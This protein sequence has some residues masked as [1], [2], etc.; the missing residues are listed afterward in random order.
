MKPILTHVIYDLDGLLLDT[1]SLYT[2][3]NL[4]LLAPFG[5]SFNWELK[6]NMLGRP[7][8]EAVGYL[9][10][11]LNLPISLEAYLKKREAILK[12]LFPSTKP[13]PGASSI[14]RYFEEKGTPQ[15]IATSSNADM[16][17]LKTQMHQSW[18]S[19]ISLVITGEDPKIQHGKPAPDIFLLAAERMN[20]K[21]EHCLVFEDS[22]SGIKAAKSAGMFVVAIPDP[23]ISIHHFQDADAIYP[24]LNDF[25]HYATFS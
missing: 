2:Q 18:L 17:A 24:S 15:A 1:E 8:N 16:Y 3:A 13:M 6:A 4:E 11:A 5:K 14:I 23:N 7:A 10:E 12:R 25:L 9:I 21:T 19:P 22:P 20:A